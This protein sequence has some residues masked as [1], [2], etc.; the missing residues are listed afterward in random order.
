MVKHHQ[1]TP[2]VMGVHAMKIISPDWQNCLSGRW[3]K[4][5][6]KGETEMQ[7]RQPVPEASDIPGQMLGMTDVLRVFEEVW[8]Q[9]PNS[10]AAALHNN[11][12]R[13]NSRRLWMQQWQFTNPFII[14]LQFVRNKRVPMSWSVTTKSH[15]MWWVP[16]QYK[17]IHQTSKM[18][19]RVNQHNIRIIRCFMFHVQVL[20]CMNKYIF[21]ISTSNK[22]LVN[23]RWFCVCQILVLLCGMSVRFAVRKL[24]SG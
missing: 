6:Q 16:V 15:L 4:M 1:I 13:L 19:F 9:Q 17:L 12:I 18:A 8:N 10:T 22:E 2:G 11:T 24:L 3:T 21:G 23:S 5:T 20:G 14:P 7:L